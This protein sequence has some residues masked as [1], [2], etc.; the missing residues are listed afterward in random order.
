MAKKEAKGESAAYT[1][2]RGRTQPFRRTVASRLLVFEPGV[3]LELT[4]EEQEQCAD[5]IANGMIVPSD[6]DA[7]GRLRGPQRQVVESLEARVEKLEAENAELKEL[8]DAATGGGD[9]A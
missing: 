4:A 2:L 3:D 9:A 6:R 5:L 1:L 8:L 7:K